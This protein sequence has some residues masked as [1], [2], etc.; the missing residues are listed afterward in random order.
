MVSV[1]PYD[2][3]CYIASFIPKANL[4]KLYGVNSLFFHLALKEVYQEVHIYHIGDERTLRCL[5]TMRCVSLR[6]E[7]HVHFI[8]HFLS[9][10]V[11]PHVGTL[12]LRPHLFG[13]AASRFPRSLRESAWK[14]SRRMN[15][16]A[17]PS[18]FVA[19]RILLRHIAKMTEVKS[20]TIGCYPLDDVEG[21]KSAAPFVHTA[22]ST[23]QSRLR[24]LNLAIPLEAYSNSKIFP[25]NLVL[26]SLE[27]LMIV[28]RKAYNTTDD[29]EITSAII[30]F[31][32]RH[33][34]S[35]ISLTIDTPDAKVDPS[36]LF[37]ALCWFPRMAKLSILH[38][39]ARLRPTDHTGIDVFL[40]KHAQQ[41]K[42]FK[43]R[44][45][46]TDFLPIPNV[47]FSHPIFR[48]DLPQLAYLDLGL[49][50]WPTS[51][52][53]E[54]TDGLVQYVGRVG[55]SLTRLAVRDCVLTF[56][57]VVSLVSVV[58]SKASELRSLE[59]HVYFLSC[60]LLDLLSQ[61]LPTLYH[62]EL[63]FDS[64]MSQDDGTWIANYYWNGYD[65]RSLACLWK[66]DF[67]C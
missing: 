51:V 14:L 9:A 35:L 47:F 45:Y 34:K 20:L 65:V 29:G 49:L 55:R 62:L 43:I 36:P 21:F 23:L 2:I 64:L 3:W 26:E 11:A 44:F 24:I 48:V 42:E 50:Q 31:I 57:Q 63:R 30:P 53:A 28:L 1:L 13:N 32:N 56:S 52:Q 40:A 46:V 59:M 7:D 67:V 5:L 66:C 22:W 18:N 25:P 41:L 27:E 33:Q 10:T 61:Q 12:I 54:V 16:T 60:S 6:I 4:V 39:V 37:N 38:P 17:K 15:K 19:S 58:S 8:C